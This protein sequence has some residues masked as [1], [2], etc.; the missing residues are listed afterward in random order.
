[1]YVLQRKSAVLLAE[2]SRRRLQVIQNPKV[3]AS[4][5][6]M[7]KGEKLHDDPRQMNWVAG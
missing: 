1:M 2:K 3:E 7:Q 4:V 5:N 6:G